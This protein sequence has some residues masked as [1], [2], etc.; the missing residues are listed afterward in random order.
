M[1]TM[2]MT[3]ILMTLSSKS[4]AL[5]SGSQLLSTLISLSAPSTPTSTLLALI[6]SL[7][8]PLY[9][10]PSPLLLLLLLLLGIPSE[11]QEFSL[12]S[13]SFSHIGGYLVIKISLSLH[14]Q[15]VDSNLDDNAQ[16]KSVPVQ[17]VITAHVIRFW[18]S[19]QYLLGDIS[20]TRTEQTLGLQGSKRFKACPGARWRRGSSPQLLRATRSR[21]N[22]PQCFLIF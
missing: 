22:C 19:H 18:P 2:P 17:C 3:V 9:P 15:T 10:L 4:S 21:P 11:I 1:T 20:L 16:A 13:S 12:S 5:H 6:F 7:H 8:L 14:L